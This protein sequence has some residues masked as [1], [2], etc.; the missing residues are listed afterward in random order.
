[1]D[2]T[3]PT[4]AAHISTSLSR[5][6]KVGKDNKTAHDAYDDQSEN[7]AAIIWMCAHDKMVLIIA[8][9]YIAVRDM[10]ASEL[11]IIFPV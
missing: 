3:P 11:P 6:N 4:R 1:M 8:A 5:N 10:A 2:G 7:G 9:S